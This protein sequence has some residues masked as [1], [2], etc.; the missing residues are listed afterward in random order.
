MRTAF[1]ILVLPVLLVGASTSAAAKDGPTVP[2]WLE[3]DA[4]YRV[5]S[6]FIDPMELSGLTTQQV[7]YTQ[8]RFRLETA[9]RPVS[10]VAIK[11]QIDALGGVLF[12]DNGDYGGD[13]SPG[14]GLALTSRYPNHAGWTVGLLEGM[15]PLDPDSYGL[16]LEGVEPI[17]INRIY[18]EAMLPFGVLRIGRQPATEGPG[19]NLHDGSRTNRWGVARHSATAD[20]ILFATKL[21][22]AFS[23][24]AH[25]GDAPYKPNLDMDDGIFIGGG[26]DIVVEDDISYGGD[27]LHQ[28][29]GLLQWKVKKPT[30]LGWDWDPFLLQVVVGSRFGD[31]FNTQVFAV[32]VSLQFGAGP[33]HFSGEFVALFGETREAS[34][35]MAALREKDAAKRVIYDQKIQAIGARAILDIEMGPVTGTL[36]FDYASGDGDPRDETPLTTYN[37][38]RDANVGLLLFEHLLAFESARSAEVGIQNLQ[39]AG[40]DSFP[41]TELASE[42]RVHNAIIAFPQVLYK[43]VDSLGLRAGVLLAW[44]AAPVTDQVMSLLNEDGKEITDDVVNWHGG[45]PA[46]FYGTELDL[47]VEW[48]YQKYFLWTVE[49]AVLLPGEALQDESG[50]AVPSFMVENRF[51]FLF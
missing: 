4:E 33:V 47:Q 26:Y 39:Q 8:Q 21:S 31:Q 44:S 18:G 50:D 36:E 37:F 20:R 22:E 46:R 27:N 3:L 13:P 2:D 1:F 17:A 43:P 51:T 9:L 12:G 25:R 23:M 11:A 6:L 5:Q 30:L 34:A 15:D 14:S 24:L 35:G 16:V 32:P 38:A 19:I 49:G 48:R 41:L 45:E 7:H 40:V 10:K 29:V 28:A 42:G